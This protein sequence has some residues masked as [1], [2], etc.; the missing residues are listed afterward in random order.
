MENLLY[1][2][3]RLLETLDID[4]EKQDETK[5]DGDR[6]RWCLK[7]KIVQHYRHS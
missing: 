1:K 4:P 3:T 7:E 5:Q 6:S 2:G